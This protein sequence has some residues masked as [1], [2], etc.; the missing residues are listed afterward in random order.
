VNVKTCKLSTYEGH[1]LFHCP[2][3]WPDLEVISILLL[4]TLL[5]II[6]SLL[7][8]LTNILSCVHG[9]HVSL[10]NTCIVTHHQITNDDFTNSNL[11][12]STTCTTRSMR[13]CKV[14]VVPP[15]NNWRKE[16]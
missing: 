9:S 3:L 15:P 6:I 5:I 13:G 11:M 7:V 12:L 16:K 14:N 10:K 1:R 8:Y 2:S 4:Q